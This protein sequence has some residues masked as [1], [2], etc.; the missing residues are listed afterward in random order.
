MT[1]QEFDAVAG[2]YDS[3]FTDTELGRELRQIVWRNLAAIVQPG[4]RVVE[5]NC[6]TG[7]DAVWLARNGVR[8]VAT[9]GSPAMLE[10]ASRKA[11]SHGMHH[12]IE[13]EILDLADPAW[14]RPDFDFDGALSDFGGLNCVPDLVP[15]ACMLG[16]SVK[17]GGHFILV[18][19]GRWCAWE[20]LWHLLHL[21]PRTA[22]RRLARPGAGARVGD[23]RVRVWYPSLGSLRRILAPEFELRR[24]LGLGVLLPPP[25]LQDVVVRRRGLFRLL[26][27]LERM[28][29]GRALVR[30]FADHLLLD[31]ERTSVMPREAR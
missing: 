7:E 21:Q 10:V 3:T 22:F 13:F 5:L 6:G 18:V 19:M 24:F 28:L 12:R 25:Y 2:R 29:A 23:G 8:V 31:F 17:P 20:I 1:I 11:A 15:L 4:A 26:K 9:D 27:H 16:R 30:N 14:K